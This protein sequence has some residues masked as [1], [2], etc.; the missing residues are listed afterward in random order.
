M[1][2]AHSSKL[3]S[4]I[5]ENHFEM[6]KKVWLWLS[7]NTEKTHHCVKYLIFKYLR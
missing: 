6:V 3:Q 5:A 2:C 4:K 7:W 1:H